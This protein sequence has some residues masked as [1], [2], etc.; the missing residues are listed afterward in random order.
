[1]TSCSISS[2][3]ARRSDSPRRVEFSERLEGFEVNREEEAEAPL[4][5]RF[6]ELMPRAERD[7]V[8]EVL[9]VK[10]LRGLRKLSRADFTLVGGVLEE[11]SPAKFLE[12]LC[13]KALEPSKESSTPSAASISR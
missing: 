12:V 9:E 3:F 11:K 5:S 2:L 1:M 8:S 13:S 6:E 4:I 10:S 7:W